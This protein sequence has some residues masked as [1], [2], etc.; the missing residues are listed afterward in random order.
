[1]PI[2]T[3]RAHA[4]SEHDQKNAPLIADLELLYE[5]LDEVL[6]E[7]T[8]AD[9]RATIEE[10]RAAAW[11]SPGTLPDE[12]LIERL[13]RDSEGRTLPL[14]RAFTFLSHLANIAE[15]V[16]HNRRRR[17]YRLA[18]SP[19]QRG[20]LADAMVRL[21]RAGI[22]KSKIETFLNNAFL[23]PVLTA[24]PTE[25][26]RRSLLQNEREITRLLTERDN[27]LVTDDEKL[28][29]RAAIKRAILSLW[30]TNEVRTFVPTVHNEI[31][32]TLVYYNYTFLDTLPKLY[33]W[34]EDWLGEK[35]SP[36]HLKPFFRMGSWIGG[37]RDGNPFVGADVL[38][39][40]ITQQAQIAFTY[41]LQTVRRLDSELPLSTVRTGVSPD[42]ETLAAKAPKIRESRKEELYRLA[43][44]VVTQRL[45][46]TA[47]RLGLVGF[48]EP[49]PGTAAY[50]RVEDFIADLSVMRDS[51][52][53]HN[54]GDLANGTL[55]HLI[56]AAEIFG[57]HL[58]SLD[59]RQHSGIHEA[60]VTALLA[61]AGLEDYGALD[62]EAR[63]NVLLR[64]LATPRPLR[65]P[66]FTYPETVT[67]ELAV[68]DAVRDI[69]EAFGPDSIRQAIISNCHSLSD[70]L[71]LWLLLKESGLMRLD[72]APEA[73]L[74]VVPLFEMIDDLE[75]AAGLMDSL[76]DLPFYRS[77]LESQNR[78]QEIMLGYS[79]SNKDGGYLTSNWTLYR[80]E[81]ELLEIA[82]KHSVRL[83]LF[84]GR[85]GSAG[86]G[87]VPS[88]DAI[89]AQ[90][91]GTVDG[92]IRITEQ[93]EVITG[94]Y[95]NSDIGRRNLEILVA[96]LLES[97][98]TPADDP[99]PEWLTAMDELSASAYT[100]YRALVYETDGFERYFRATTPINEISTMNLGSR[101]VAR[102]KNPAI[103]SLR[104]IPWVFSWSQCRLMLPAWYGFGSAVNAFIAAHGE[105][106]WDLLHAMYRGW[107]FFR[108]MLD[109]MEMVFSKTNLEIGERYSALLDD[110]ELRTAIF[111]SISEEWRRAHDS[112][113]RITGH[114][115]ILENNPSLSR[116]LMIRLPYLDSLSLIQRALLGCA[117]SE[118]DNPGVREAIKLTINGVAAGLRNSG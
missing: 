68:F 62:E 3:L 29:N 115:A 26:H 15:D 94:K 111:R 113:L 33:A 78:I 116:S 87:G 28:E 108:I 73:T 39:E 56:R 31:V 57:F 21:D 70:I 14:I 75:R 49:A 60:V 118:P 82:R 95:A 91:R 77:I 89:T 10:L 117:R 81:C 84:H 22:D 48:M 9:E 50:D 53:A 83:R 66:Y 17:H 8:D 101:P 59:V 97:C 102:T 44:S 5:L 103:T 55:R 92:Q 2:A 25:V 76:F 6:S 11:K 16:H 35:A 46:A 110:A 19:P 13:S 41:Y 18:G 40:A 34:L 27:P 20:S 86:R 30:Q 71:E 37:D 85:G 4:E 105:A 38:R 23:S 107:P 99:Q 72:G 67:R 90:P 12:E 52:I 1:M 24:H 93:G 64:E 45:R 42:L 106:G 114:K 7:Q 54:G 61:A 96:A 74:Q 63:C 88:F 98:L 109:T 58:A 79:D 112:L 104:A 36:V 51:L 69:Q 47:K 65:S 43:L 80:A 32:N 100:A